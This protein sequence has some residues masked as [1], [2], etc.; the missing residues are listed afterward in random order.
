MLEIC[1]RG[2]LKSHHAA[3]RQRQHVVPAHSGA[4]TGVG[5]VAPEQGKSQCRQPNPAPVFHLHSPTWQ[6]PCSFHSLRV[7]SISIRKKNKIKIFNSIY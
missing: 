3:D 6:Q 4:A 2:L 1:C 5:R 7:F